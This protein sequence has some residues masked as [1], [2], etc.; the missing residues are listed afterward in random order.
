MRRPT[1]I[2]PLAPLLA[3]AVVAT[4]MPYRALSQDGREGQSEIAALK[5]EI[6][7]LKGMLPSQSH[8]MID[9]EYHFANL[10]F[11][12]KNGNWPLATFYLNETRGHLNW[13]VRVRAV[14]PLS[15][16]RQL[17][18]RPILKG[19]EDGALANLRS[20]VE[21][22]D[23]AA[24]EPAYRGMLDACYSCHQA[25]EK[26]FLKPQIPERPASPLIDDRR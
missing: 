24:F 23:S 13:A 9:V 7:T 2:T 15:E 11:A 14:R 12:A 22:Q 21:K 19:I 26:P 4:V 8:T 5:A 10:W 3:A 6:E 16:G 20:A 18:L 17:D 1:F 25:A